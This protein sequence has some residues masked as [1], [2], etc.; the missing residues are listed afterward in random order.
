MINPTSKNSKDR[1]IITTTDYLTCRSE[2][3]TA[4]NCSTDTVARFIF[5]NIITRFG[6]PMSLTSDQGAHFISTTIENITTEFLIQHHKRNPYHPQANGIVEA[7]NN[8]LERGLTKVCCENKEDWDE[9][10]PT[11]L[12]E[13]GCGAC[14]IHYSKFSHCTDHTD[15]KGR[16]SCTETHRVTRT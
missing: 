2:A 6:C 3:T 11:I 10:L 5:E 14:K 7:F 4:Q 12:W 8:I 13:R 1:Y 9:I 15:V 16:I